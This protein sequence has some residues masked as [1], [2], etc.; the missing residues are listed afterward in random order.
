[1]LIA[2]TIRGMAINVTTKS[3]RVRLT[4]IENSPHDVQR[5][6]CRQAVKTSWGSY[7]ESVKC[8][9]IYRFLTN[10]A[11][12]SRF[13]HNRTITVHKFPRIS[14]YNEEKLLNLCEEDAMPRILVVDDNKETVRA[15]KVYLERDGF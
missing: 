10:A 14:F 4:V 13:P 12:S 9:A 1:M 5:A 8:I 6:L 15:V 11:Q 3:K 2:P 7:G